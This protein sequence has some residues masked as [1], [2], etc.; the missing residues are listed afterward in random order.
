[1]SN[2]IKR[3]YKGSDAE[4]L[5]AIDIIVQA[6]IDNQKTLVAKRA[7]WADPFLSNLQTEI[8]TV[9]QTYIGVDS[10]KDLR[11]ATQL[12]TQIQ[13][14][15]INALE[16]VKVQIERDFRDDKPQGMNC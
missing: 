13:S 16:E 11:T 9:T 10:T 14:G 6:A 8:N 7:S 3:A 2:E 12:V 1:M 5:T 15:A 4:M